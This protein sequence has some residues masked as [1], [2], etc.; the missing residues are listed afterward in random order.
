MLV[1]KLETDGIG[2][3]SYEIGKAIIRRKQQIEGEVYVY[4]VEFKTDGSCDLP[5]IEVTHDRD[6]GAWELVSKCLNDALLDEF[7]RKNDLLD[8]E[9]VTER[10]PVPTM[11]PNRDPA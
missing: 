10:N 11:R 2:G 1:V 8:D 5:S 3:L 9:P 4:S 6:D 7:V